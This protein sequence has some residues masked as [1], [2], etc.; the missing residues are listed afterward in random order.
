MLHAACNLNYKLS[1]NHEI[2]HVKMIGWFTAE[3]KSIESIMTM[4]HA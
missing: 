3:P 2:D 1:V 4:I